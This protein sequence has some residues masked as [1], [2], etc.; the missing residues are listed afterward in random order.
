MLCRLS[1]FSQSLAWLAALSWLFCIEISAQT[2]FVGFNTP[3]QYTNSFNAWNDA[4][5]ID[6]GAYSFL[7]TPTNGVAGGGGISVFQ[8]NDTTATYKLGSW[9]FSTNGSA[10]LM[11]VMIKANGQ[12]SGN[13][14]QFGILNSNAN[15][16]NANAGVS[17]ESYRFIPG[18]TTWSLREQYRTTNTLFE[19][20]LGTVNF[21]L[22]NWYR[23]VLAMT[24]TSGAGDYNASCAI[25]DY[26]PDGLT[27]GTNIV[28]FP[29]LRN[30]TAQEIATNNAVWPAFRAFQSGGVDAWDSF[31]V[32]R[33]DSKPVFTVPLTNT[34]VP[35]GQ[36]QQFIA[37]ADG[38]GVISYTWFTN[39]TL[40]AGANGSSYTTPPV[41]STYTNISVIAANSNGSATNSA[42]V[43]VFI[44][45]TATVTNFPAT[46]VQTTSATLAGQVLT[47]GGD[48]PAVTL[49]YGP[50]NGGANASA[51][52]N[53]IP[54]GV[55]S[56]TFTQAVAGLAP[57]TTYYF[58][59]RAVNLAGSGWGTPSLSFTTLQPTFPILSN[60]SATSI[61]T[62]G[63]ALRGQV[64][65]SGVGTPG[66]VM[67]YGPVDGG[68]NAIAW[69]NAVSLGSQSGA[70]TQA[71]TGLIPSTGYYYAAR[72]TNSAGAGWGTPSQFFFTQSTNIAPS[73]SVAVLTRH[74]DNARLGANTN[75]TIL[76]LGNVNTNTFGLILSRPVDDWV[77]AQPLIMTNVDIPGRGQHN[78]VIVCTVNDSI[79]AFD[80]D[81]TSVIQP[82]W[83]TNY[84]TAT[85]VPPR[86]SDMT[87]ACGGNYQ[88]FH[89]NMG[90]VG[91]PV[92]DPVTL[93]MYVVV[94]T[95]ENGVNF[96]QR[97]RALDVRTGAD[98]PGS[99]VVISATYPGTGD[100]SV[101]GV[102][103]FDPMKEGHRCALALVNGIVYLA[104]SSHC[105]W[106]PYHGWLIGY[107]AQTLARTTVYNTTPTGGLGGIWMSGEAPAV[108]QTGH[109]YVETGNGTFNPTNNNYSDS[110][111]KLS[112]TNGVALVDYFTP[113]NQAALNSADADV[114][115]A[116]NIVLPDSVGSVAHPRLLL[117]GSKGG[118]IYLLDRDNLGKYNTVNDSQIVQSIIGGTGQCYD[119]PAYFNYRFYI[120]GTGNPLRAFSISNAVMSTT[121]T[122]QSPG[123]FGFSAP[124]PS[125]SANGTSNAIVW[126]LQVDGWGSGQPA[127]LHA[128]NATNLALEIYNSNMAG[129]RDRPGGA[130]KFTVPTVANGKVYV[131][132]QYSLAVYGNA[133]SWVA[134]P[135]FTPNGGTFTNSVMVT[136]SDATA[137]AS[138][139]YTLDNSTPTTSSTLYTGPFLVTN[140]LAVRARAFKAG[141]VDSATTTATFLNSSAIGN[142]TGLLGAYYSNHFPTNAFSGAASL[143][144]TDA[145]V[146]FNWGTGSPDPLISTD[147]FT[148]RWTGTVQP[149]FN[150]VYTFYTTTD[151]GVRLWINNQL[152]IDHWVDQGSTEWG[153][154]TSNLFLSQQKYNVRMEYY[155]NGGG[156]A[157]TLSWSSPSTA[158]NII[159]QNQLYPVTNQLPSVVISSPVSGSSFTAAATVTVN[160]NASEAG[161]TIS[162]VDFY[163]NSTFL[164]SISNSPYAN[165]V[166]GLG[167][168]S[169]A[170]TARAVDGTGVIV[171]SAPVNITVTAGTG[172]PYGISGRAATPA[173]LAMPGAITDP[174]PPK[175]SL[176]G[177]FNNTTNL[178]VTGALIPYTVNVPLWS[179][180]ALK[181]RWLSVPNNGVPFTP[182]EQIS[183][184][185]NGEWNFPAG[186]VFVK[187]F[188]L[189][190]DE[191]NPA[192]KRRLETRLL[193]RDVFGAVYGV[194]Y[195]WRP[196]NSDADLL[197][198]SL[199]EDIIVTNASGIRT[200]TWY[201]P[202]P[203]DCLVCHTPAANYVLGVKTRQLNGNFTYPLTGATDNQLRSMNRVGLFFPS[204][205]ETSIAGFTH[206][207]ALT[208][209]NASLEERARSYLDANCA[210]CHRP[211]GPGPTFD[212]R[213][214]TPLTNQNI[215]NVLLQKGDLGVDNAR[216]VVPKDVWR[217]I[218]RARMNTT[219]AAV[220]MPQLARN[221]V[222]TNAVSV[223]DDWINSL[224]GT[225][226]LAP[227]SLTPTGGLFAA[228]ANVVLSHPDT[229]A[230]LR[231]TLDNTLPTSSSAIYTGPLTLT[232]NVVLQAKAFEA[233]FNDSVAVSG[234]FIVRPPIFF[235]TPGYFSNN[236]FQLQIS[237]LAGKTYLLQATAD[238]TNWA[239]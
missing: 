199:S 10:I 85:A 38:P 51:W 111:L 145:V 142:G 57:F 204:F 150:E 13:K 182:D 168:G 164:G 203:S 86:N 174:L 135:A 42:A 35:L 141:S 193:V 212:A 17:F 195:K 180:G 58:T 1:L 123:T 95:K 68:T 228:S 148:V 28:T 129:T 23:F 176:T 37:L 216:V 59:A 227:P 82:Y 134:A 218:L 169:Y 130:I 187:H 183:F 178:A 45:T 49:Y 184:A 146:N 27:P 155:E 39:G 80:A 61:S 209:T 98:R 83:Q 6:G 43:S 108:D 173:F 191:S 125:V 166:V 62:T 208:N 237:G 179:D 229:N 119:T 223:I 222:D 153:G 230:I 54:L 131:G 70:F 36:T 118:T 207:S 26:G 93:T 231:Y 30:N 139:Y 202:S 194:T 19:T 106:G 65:S 201:Y 210:Q 33:P 205:D 124:T 3:G 122:S 156:A 189:N 88:D 97:L 18:A 91:T 121:P 94:R 76:T 87:G 196:D 239:T 109:L 72:G 236:Q 79:Y 5:G 219:D 78:L 151:D 147:H 25:Y 163:A 112:T 232:N 206:L 101:G 15:G 52:S 198:T 84:L 20:T 34:I 73:S 50:V 81:D 154:S 175:L 29:T 185:P 165:T 77:Y 220:K 103:T 75:E 14:V 63:A 69:S 24:N 137:G 116:A 217:S 225:P 190:T 9:D 32:F 7:E 12:V 67:F 55:Q 234:V 96:V 167:V 40:V 138:I 172:Q 157:A 60:L 233:G 160:A 115:S 226:A 161:G 90:I 104:W 158:K 140:S 126:A 214:D 71:V 56:G 221:L 4:G 235:A 64:V 117:G 89:G 44:Y 16:L 92:I 238:F 177:A 53:S 128:Y 133:S 110:F 100:G 171:T 114:G 8:N 186:T 149:Q 197:T 143:V 192:V 152:I 11:S 48:I 211:T 144:R 127:I 21:T 170:L 66:V 181:T 74:N 22:G 99:P 120:S 105:D 41:N 107:N 215:I 200:Q 46:A 132:S 224:P 102:L 113:Y 31:L 2:V 162:R 47:T 213:Y 188:E 159:P 136:I